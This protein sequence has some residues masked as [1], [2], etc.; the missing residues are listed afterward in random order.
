LVGPNTVGSL[1]QWQE[2]GYK[3]YGGYGRI[4]ENYILRGEY[5]SALQA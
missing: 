2:M 3:W 1:E 5:S 4:A